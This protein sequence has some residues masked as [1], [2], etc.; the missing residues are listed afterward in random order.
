[1]AVFFPG[2]CGLDALARVRLLS[3]VFYPANQGMGYKLIRLGAFGTILTGFS[4]P[5]SSLYPIW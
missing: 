2:G 4:T 1:M 5:A 3:P